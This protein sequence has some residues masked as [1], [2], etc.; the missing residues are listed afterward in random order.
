M[1]FFFNSLWPG[2]VVWLVLYISDYTLTIVCAR[3]YRSG[4]SEKLVFEGSYELTPYFQ[5]DIDSLRA[6]S[7]RFVVAW[8]V[9]GLLLAWVWFLSLQSAREF[10][11][12]LLGSMILIELTI[13]V[14]HLR[15]FSLFRGFS[16]PT[17]VR[18]RIEYS[19][20]FI[21][22]NSSR[23]MFVFSCLYVALF[24][25]T[26][27]WFVLGGATACFSTAIKHHR[28]ARAASSKALPT[29]EMQSAT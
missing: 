19:R 14:R 25:F 7:P 3:Q 28:L 13:H 17:C 4:V 23:E 20:P 12:F 21:L 5:R 18:G 2:L 22:K 27:S 9:S 26:Q 24:A 16:D 15:N 10:Y 29:V 11:T 6:I 8:V 1:P